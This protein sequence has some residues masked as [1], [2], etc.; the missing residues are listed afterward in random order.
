MRVKNLEL[1]AATVTIL[2]VTAG[3][4]AYTSQFGKP[5][6]SGLTGHLMG[7]VGFVLMLMTE[8]LYSL[9][10][11]YKL[12]RWGKMQH[13]LSFHIYTGLVGPYLVLLHSA[14]KFQGLAG[15]LMLM[16]V[17]I[18]LSGFVGRYLYT[19]I[20]RSLDGE[21][22]DLPHLVEPA[23]DAPANLGA[24]RARRY[25][26]LWHAVHIP[27]GVATFTVAFVHIG[28]A[29]YYATLLK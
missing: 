8:V 14:F 21:E 2:G 5:E 24:T 19:A 12:S 4:L 10:K 26:A 6:A 22:V 9:R 3:Y 17:I 27:L 18:V 7:V 1:W 16:T 20:P 11:R 28:A 15:V 25:L 29:L 13:W 23:E